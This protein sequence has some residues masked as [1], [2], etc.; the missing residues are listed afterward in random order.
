MNGVNLIPSRRREAKARKAHLLK[1]TTGLAVYG[2]ALL[3]AYLLCTHSV[4]SG[5]RPLDSES[6]TVAARLNAANC[7]VMV[8]TE[9]LTLAQQRMQAG[10]AIGQ[11]P[12]WGS[13]LKV[14]AQNLGDRIVLDSCQL[15]KVPLVGESLPPDDASNEPLLLELSGW[16]NAQADVSA[17]V[18]R[19]EQTGLFGEVKLV[20]TNRQSFLD[21]QAVAFQLEC[22]F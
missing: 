7:R 22:T 16:A 11:Q 6:M 10:R 15:R 14:L 20:K 8:L 12:D 21:R 9:E 2:L 4:A 18:L 1:L 13:L 5:S 17:Y 19:L 3:G